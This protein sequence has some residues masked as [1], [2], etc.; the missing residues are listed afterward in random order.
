MAR[1][2]APTASGRHCGCDDPPVG[3]SSCHA[4]PDGLELHGVL[5]LA[6]NPEA[7]VYATV[8][9]HRVHP[10]TRGTPVELVVDV[11]NTGFVTAPVR[12]VLLAPGDGSVIVGWDHAAL[13]GEQHE[14]RVL[15]LTSLV[16]GFVDVTISF[17]LPGDPIDLGGRD[18]VNL[19]LRVG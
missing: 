10:A 2:D 16:D 9:R 19:L 4:I 13:S 6:V 11:V 1:P 17:A 5:S 15:A 14:E 12:P 18:R 8:E 3:G 7:R